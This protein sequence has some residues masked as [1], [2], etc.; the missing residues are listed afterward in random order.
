MTL[1]IT[2]TPTQITIAWIAYFIIWLVLFIY[3]RRWC[4]KKEKEAERAHKMEQ[5]TLLEFE[6]L[7]GIDLDVFEC[8]S[9]HVEYRAGCN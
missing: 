5:T 4:L 6:H 2:L 3:A 8:Q 7:S 9:P 1:L